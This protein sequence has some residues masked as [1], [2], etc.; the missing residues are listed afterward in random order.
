MPWMLKGN[1]VHK[2]NAD[3][4]AGEL[5]KCHESHEKAVAHMRALYANVHEGLTEF[6]MTIVKKPKD[7]EMD[8]RSVNSDTGF[9]FYEER[10]SRELFLDMVSRIENNAPIPDWLK[11]RVCEDG[12]CGGMPYSSVAHYKS[13]GGKNVPAI[14]KTLYVDGDKLKSTGKFLDTRLGKAVYKSVTKDFVEKREDKIRISIGFID[15]E[16]SHGDRYTFVRKSVGQKC[17]L[18]ME[19]IGDKIYKKGILV[20]LAFTRQPANPRTDVEVEKSMTSKLE[21]AK[22]IVEDEEAL[23]DMELKS[24]TSENPE[25]EVLVVKADAES[26]QEDMME[27]CEEGDEDCKKKM[28]AHGEAHKS[29]DEDD[30]PLTEEAKRKDVS[31]AD[32]KRA[33]QEYGDVAYADETNKKYPID[34][35][36]HIRAAWNYIHQERNANKYSDHGAAIKSKIVAAWKKKIGGAPPAATEKSLASPEVELTPLQTSVSAFLDKIEIIKS[37]GLTGDNALKELQSSF[38]ELGNVVRAE[39]TPKP[40]PEIV[41]NQQLEST[42]RSMFESFEQRMLQTLSQ[43][44]APIQAE[45]GELRALS[46]AGKPVT[47]KKSEETPQPRSLSLNLVQKSA[48]EKLTQPVSQFSQIARRSVGLQD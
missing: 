22:S 31:E 29:V 8:F 32:K 2:K 3:G 26:S 25:E 17:P 4:S 46:L 19:G 18:C 27:D 45:V 13:R 43:T 20:H 7:G 10:M 37:Q 48:V 33:E 23:A 24:T 35:E 44:V 30:E 16:H 39:F 5:L 6:S 38:D 12:W 14:I 40:S 36:E 28:Q 15:M 1:C 47:P 11:E 41:A 9:D 34:T 21:D 42:L